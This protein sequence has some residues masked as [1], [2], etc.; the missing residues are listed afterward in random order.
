VDVRLASHDS[1]GVTERDLR[2]ADFMDHVAAWP[3][4][5]S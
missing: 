5:L 1:G 4:R 2:L 3:G